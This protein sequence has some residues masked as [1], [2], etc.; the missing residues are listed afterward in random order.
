MVNPVNI[1]VVSCLRQVMSDV[2]IG[3]ASKA[4]ENLSAP[5]EVGMQMWEKR[6]TPCSA[7]PNLSVAEIPANDLLSEELSPYV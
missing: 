4:R 7:E 5:A 6:S 3:E 1:R 2:E